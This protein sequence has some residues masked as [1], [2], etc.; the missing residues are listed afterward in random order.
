MP[1]DLP[2]D[3][4]QRLGGAD[5]AMQEPGEIDKPGLR[6]GPECAFGGDLQQRPRALA[7]QRPDASTRRSGLG[8]IGVQDPLVVGAG[9]EVP[10]RLPILGVCHN[11]RVPL[12][13][14]LA[15]EHKEGA[16][17]AAEGLS[18]GGEPH[19]ASGRQTPQQEQPPIANASEQPTEPTNPPT[20]RQ[21]GHCCGTHGARVRRCAG[22]QTSST[23]M[24]RR[25]QSKPRTGHGN[26][27]LNE[28]KNTSRV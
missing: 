5:L 25:M 21:T 28:S 9:P 6:V 7:R 17:G 26:D 2:Q 14:A 23:W 10:E 27:G 13:L 19:I 8:R 12:P 24:L 18:Q 22:Q 20:R 4:A 16:G 11:D 15:I 1:Q 3:I